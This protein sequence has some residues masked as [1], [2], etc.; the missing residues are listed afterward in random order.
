MFQV[1]VLSCRQNNTATA[2]INNCTI[3]ADRY[4]IFTSQGG[5]ITVNGGVYKGGIA[6]ISAQDVNSKVIVNSGTF[7]GELNATGGGT[8][9]INGG[10]F[11]VNPSTITGVTING[12]VSDNGN[13]TWTVY[14]N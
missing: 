4:A 3:D 7:V 13:G 6:V 12:V 1:A 11:S 5:T 14:S 2:V 10:T 9:V 8:I